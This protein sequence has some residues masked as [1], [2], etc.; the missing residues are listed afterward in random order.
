MRKMANAKSGYSQDSDQL[1]RDLNE[2]EQRLAK[3]WVDG[4][5][6]AISAILS[7]DWTVIDIAGRVLTKT[8]VLQEMFETPHVTIE[9]MTI[10]E[11]KVRDFGD[12]A[13]VT[14]R[15]VATGRSGETRNTVTLRF[16]DVF[17][18]HGGSWR[19][20]ASQGTPVAP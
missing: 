15:T 4:D 8:Q 20:V 1:A 13:I 9:A 11:V 17:A 3:A 5:R 7:P 14:G 12:I 16:T 18:R 6:E 10:D 2:I 19:A